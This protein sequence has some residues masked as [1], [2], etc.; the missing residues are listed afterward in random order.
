MT[1]AATPEELESLARWRLRPGVRATAVRDGV[2]LRGW[3]G[4]VTLEGSPALPGL[5]GLLEEAL[6]AGDPAALCAR[7]PS[8]TPLRGAL[9]TL[10]SQLHAHGM[11]VESRETADVAA[12]P[13]TVP[14]A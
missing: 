3:R 5:W 12:A 1:P 8:G 4:A 6:R 2:H 7:A 9:T 10:L 13:V 11:L 14:A